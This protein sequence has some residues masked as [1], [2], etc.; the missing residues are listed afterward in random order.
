MLYLRFVAEQIESH[1]QS[2]PWLPQP[3]GLYG[4]RFGTLERTLWLSRMFW[5]AVM[6]HNTSVASAASGATSCF[7]NYETSHKCNRRRP[8]LIR[9][10][11]H[12][13]ITWLGTNLLQINFIAFFIR[14]AGS[15]LKFVTISPN[16]EDPNSPNNKSVFLFNLG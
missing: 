5:K 9:D 6:L 2:L 1:W 15:A 14:L 3:S 7:A 12:S 13:A 11:F 16:N 4:C 10:V 8:T